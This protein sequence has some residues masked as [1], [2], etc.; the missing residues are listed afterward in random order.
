MS[1]KVCIFHE[2]GNRFTIGSGQFH[3][4]WVGPV[5][6]NHPVEELSL[7]TMCIFPLRNIPYT[8]TFDILAFCGCILPKRTL[9][10]TF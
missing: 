3:T 5:K 7:A 1:D 9:Q 8:K 2:V 10:G 4:F 6:K